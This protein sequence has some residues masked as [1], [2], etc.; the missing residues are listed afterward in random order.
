MAER[1][2]VAHP[3]QWIVL[4]GAREHNL[5]NVS[6]R[7][8][9]NT[10]TVFTG[11]SGSGKSSLVFATIAVESQRQLNETFTTFVRNRLPRYEKP[12]ADR[13]AGLSTAVVVD[14]TPIGG[15][16]RSTV[17]TVTDIY[18]IIRVL[19]SRAGK[20]SAGMATMYSFNTPEGACPRCAGL[21]RATTVDL[22][23]MIDKSLSL[24]QGALRFPLFAV[25]MVQWHMFAQSGLFDL[26][27]PLERYTEA[28]WRHLIDGSD[29]EIKIRTKGGA[30]TTYEGLVD[31]FNRLYLNRDLST[32]SERTRKAVE[33]FTT[34]G[35][36]PL[37]R[38]ARLNQAALRTEIDGYTIADYSAM[39]VA[40][41]IE[42][43]GKIDH[44]LG[45]PLAEQ[46]ITGLRRLADIGLGYL[47]LGRE[48]PTLSG[49]EAQRLKMVRFLGS[50]LTGMTYIFDEPSVGLHPRDV[51]RM[52]KLLREL[53]DNGNTVLVVEHDR[54][55]IAI[56]DHVIDM[57]PAAGR[58]GGLIVYE[59]DYRGLCGADTA[60]G[61]ALRRERPMK[62]EFRTPTGYLRVEG[63]DLHNLRDIAVDIPTG[64]LTVFTGVAGSGKSTLVS[65]VFAAEH[66]EAVVVDQGGLG[67]SPRSTPASHLGVMDGI[68]KAFAQAN[69]VDAGRFSFNSTG[70][71]RT[72]GGRGE[73]TA[74]MAFMD[75]VTTRC[76]R[77]RGT[78]YDPD[79]LEYTLR[80]KNI[81]QVLGLTAE[82]AA[83]F[84][85][86]STVRQRISTLVAVGLGY[87]TLGQPLSTLSG[88]ERQR[89]KLAGE[90]EK[91]GGIYI[92]DEPTTGL[93]MSDIDTLL[94][95]LDR[96][97]DAGNTVLV[98]E[99]DLDV[100]EHADHII[101]LGPDGGRH[102]GRVVFQGTPV[103]LLAAANSHTADY[104]RRDLGYDLAE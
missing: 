18:S 26:D 40:E 61:R 87:L 77:C 56:A 15:N 86:E 100:I 80:G 6:V 62:T 76:E 36:C 27:K 28:E 10:I 5:R 14:Q 81:V 89:L 69:S 13:I 41:L 73:V 16:A 9:K 83:R 48:T 45:T 54:D 97:V 93:H 50:A 99:H 75:P 64:V 7:I 67:S 94:K 96:I 85:T 59:G 53:R 20:P 84:F 35:L 88:G 23:A 39:E 30:S 92:L 12:D 47:T 43:L 66:P 1:S 51:G 3:A 68:R 52:N 74:D 58:H 55:V 78:R 49:G 70:A 95:L 44:P 17:G 22:D 37:C 90:L 21:G 8:P 24:N 101:D 4:E 65:E 72:C 102:G 31:K 91:S 98:I 103:E 25:G 63:A 11:V 79:V 33:Q 82:E 2:Q 57:G 42:I 38:G 32:L 19:F 104:L 34:Q 46:A 29:T 60:T 71:C